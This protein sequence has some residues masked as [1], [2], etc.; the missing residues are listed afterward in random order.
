MQGTHEVSLELVADLM[1]VLVLAGADDAVPGAV[2]DAIYPAEASKRL[3]NH[4]GYT[5]LLAHVTQSSEAV[6]VV[7]DHGL[8][9]GLVDSSDC[10]NIVTVA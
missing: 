4:P 1:L 7:L 6:L 2:G 3:L 9:R 10:C 8:W 5:I